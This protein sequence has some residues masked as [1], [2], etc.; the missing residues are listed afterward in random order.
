[1]KIRI[2]EKSVNLETGSRGRDEYRWEIFNSDG[3][4]LVSP[5]PDEIPFEL[6]SYAQC[7]PGE[8][9]RHALARAYALVKQLSNPRYY[10][11]FKN[12]SQSQIEGMDKLCRKCKAFVDSGQRFEIVR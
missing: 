4:R 9:F 1:M 7:L 3:S 5:Y 6:W 8:S 2:V 12:Q 10:D 11:T